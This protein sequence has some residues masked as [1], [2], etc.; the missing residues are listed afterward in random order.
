MATEANFLEKGIAFFSPK[1]AAE[2]A[3]DKMRFD[4]LS[5]NQTRSYDAGRRHKGNGWQIPGRSSANSQVHPDMVWLRERASDLVRNNPFAKK[6]VQVITTNVIGTGI[7]PS[8]RKGLLSK[9]EEKKL[10]NLWRGWAETTECDF[11]GQLT[12]YGLQALGWKASV[13]RGDAFFRIIR[14]RKGPVPIKLQ[15]LESD[16]L[17]HM[18]DGQVFGNGNYCIMGI[19]FDGMTHQRVAYWMY[20][21]HPSDNY[22]LEG[23]L[24]SV[25]VPREE[26]IHWYE[27]LRPGQVRGIPHGVAA[28]LTIKDLDNYADAQLKRQMIAASFAVFIRKTESNFIEQYEKDANDRED[29]GDGPPPLHEKIHPGGIEYLMPGEDISFA[30]PPGTVGYDEYTR[31]VIR[32]IACGYLVTYESISGDYSNVNFSSGRLGWLEFNRQVGDWQDNTIIPMMC[33]PVWSAFMS[34]IKMAGSYTNTIVTPD[35][36]SPRRPMIDPYKEAK[37]A[38]EMV[39]HGF[40]TRSEVIRE[41]GDDPER[42]F[43]EL[44]AEQK[45]ADAAGMMLAS[46]GKWDA[47]RVN[48]GA[49]VYLKSRQQMKAVA[50]TTKPKKTKPTPVAKE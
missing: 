41:N 5:K 24:M 34:A 21:I 36:T 12:F 49:D 39:R 23:N 15:L 25:R 14:Q 45:E 46:D 43:D 28:F 20:K 11:N 48:F 44:L 10:M 30:N 1:Y 4:I 18:R 37:G 40:T 3:A 13:E 2:R 33:H 22:P 35:W 26:I 6:A 27:L 7:K 8:I 42:V 19:E 17:D 9:P 16:F 31:Q 32:S 29:A 38:A 47:A 50:A